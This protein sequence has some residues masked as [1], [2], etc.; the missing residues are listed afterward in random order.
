MFNGQEFLTDKYIENLIE[1][2]DIFK[3]LQSELTISFKFRDKNL[4]PKIKEVINKTIEIVERLSKYNSYI[5]ISYNQYRYEVNIIEDF[6]SN[7]KLLFG[8][9]DIRIRSVNN[10]NYKQRE[11]TKKKN[12]SYFGDNEFKQASDYFNN[13][14]D[15]PNQNIASTTKVATAQISIKD[16]NLHIQ[17]I[18]NPTNLL[19]TPNWKTP[20][21]TEKIPPNEKSLSKL[22][23]KFNLN[24]LN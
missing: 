3:N 18:T 2:C 9:L 21:K 6:I 5:P 10:D 7:Y 13:I 14:H 20:C 19:P 24:N 15:C 22:K 8:E 23:D 16:D 12:G 1:K 4:N 11:N 17:P